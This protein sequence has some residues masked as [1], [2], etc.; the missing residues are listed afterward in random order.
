MGFNQHH[1]PTT[2]HKL[3]KFIQAGMRLRFG[4][5]EF[6]HKYQSSG[7]GGTRS[8]LAMLHAAPPAKY[9]MAPRG[10][11]WPTGS[12]QFFWT[13]NTFRFKKFLNP[14]SLTKICFTQNILHPNLDPKYF[15]TQQRFRPIIFLTKHFLTKH[16]FDQTFFGLK[17]FFFQ[18][19]LYQIFF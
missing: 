14:I 13:Q 16:F 5:V 6:T 7:A 8:P 9:K 1:P 3:F 17:K 19:F 15:C 2:H 4:Y 12:G 11:K 10:P 18:I